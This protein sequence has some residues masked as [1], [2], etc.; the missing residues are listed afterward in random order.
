VVALC[1]L[2]SAALVIHATRRVGSPPLLQVLFAGWVAAPFGLLAAALR[3]SPHWPARMRATLAAVCV[4]ACVASL[5]AYAIAA[6]AV[7]KPRAPIFVLTPPLTSL[8]AAIALIV[9]AVRARR[10]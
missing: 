1:A 4:L 6:F 9:A 7:A 8:L 3:R 2:A 10:P 5:A